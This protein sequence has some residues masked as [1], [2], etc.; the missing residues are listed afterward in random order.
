[1]ANQIRGT[2]ANDKLT[3]TASDD[4]I[5]GLGGNDLIS[6]RAGNDAIIGG[7]TDTGAVPVITA[8]GLG[9]A[10]PSVAGL[11]GGGGVVAWEAF[12][13][14]SDA[15]YGVYAT[16]VDESGAVTRNNI[17]VATDTAGDEVNPSA[18]SLANGGF[19]VAWESPQVGTGGAGTG[20]LYA[21][22]FNGA[23]DAS[24]GPIALS[25]GTPVSFESSASLAGLVGGG[26][27]SAW[28]SAPGTD[29]TD[30]F[31][32]VFNDAGAVTKDLT[33]VNATVNFEQD[34]PAV[35]ALS[36]GGFVVA[37]N[38]QVL[39]G[40]A[41]LARRF[42]ASG[43]ASG[44]EFVVSSAG[45]VDV[46]SWKPSVSSLPD[47]GFV[48][49]WDAWDGTDSDIYVRR[50]DAGGNPVTA[51][52]RANTTT[53][54]LQTEASAVGL[55]DGS[56]VVTWNSVTDA[57]LGQGVYG[58]RYDKLARPVGPEFR[59]DSTQT[60]GDAAPAAAAL[61]DGGFLVAWDPKGQNEAIG[62]GI[63]ANRVSGDGIDT[64]D[65]SAAYRQYVVTESLP[66][67][68]TVSGPD[69]SDT[70]S[71]IENLGFVDGRETFD[72]YDHMAQAY[73]LYFATLDRAPDPLGLNYQ[74][75]R[76]DGGTSLIDVA[77]GFV[78]SPEFQAV[79][80][81]LTN[82]EFV[83]L[84]YQNVLDR[85]AAPEEINYHVNRLQSGA[86]R[87]EV[88]V[89]FSEAPEHILKH[90][91]AVDDGL[92]DIDEGM[93]SI[94]RLYFGM[95]ER[96]PET[97]GLVY[98]KDALA[99]GLTVQQVANNFSLSPEFQAKYGP[100][101][102]TAYVTQLYLNVLDRA[103]APNEV[104]YHV[105][106]LETGATRGDVAAGFTEAPEYQVNTLPLV[107]EGIAVADAGFIL[108]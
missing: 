11:R 15:G 107:D 69:G 93:A 34:Q 72:P 37:W 22:L 89:G 18:A 99:Q 12:E 100:L 87:P 38:S 51:E 59:L 24:S 21:R 58:Q 64:A 48:V 6:G 29:G 20:T 79:Y 81:P 91:G 54:N 44:G 17:Q 96:T 73:R 30:I 67:N 47:G 82:E 101:N 55:S 57:D 90:I 83:A 9:Q 2:S 23:G 10:L 60:Q 62:P 45:V 95:L 8:G 7:T 14:G 40:E 27:V 88:V 103:P 94:S 31:L 16:L 75:A 74:S 46:E 86:S 13:K 3:G 77:G 36:N 42:D 61:T 78:N 98:Y 32:R 108:P 56:F 71:W 68:A 102:N 49:S 105:N 106:R 70:L 50:F 52:L 26:F 76:L 65:F 104:A 28:S 43:N 33:R 25:P 41:I 1:M 53:A 84:L 85:P 35:A 63:F 4:V 66:L 5:L 19:V 39:D 80:G 92:W 97:A